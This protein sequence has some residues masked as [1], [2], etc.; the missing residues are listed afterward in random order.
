MQCKP[1]M[2]F[3]A[4]EVMFAAPSFCEGS[5]IHFLILFI[6]TISIDASNVSVFQSEKKRILI[7]TIVECFLLMSSLM[8]YMHADQHVFL[9]CC[10][11]VFTSMTRL[12]CSTKPFMHATNG[13]LDGVVWCL[14]TKVLK[15]TIFYVMTDDGGMRV[16]DSWKKTKFSV[17]SGIF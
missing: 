13:N 12:I 8:D 7:M 5:I 14:Q 6:G 2:F 11:D 15:N 1:G 4:R 9:E 16:M 10:L 3:S 17:L